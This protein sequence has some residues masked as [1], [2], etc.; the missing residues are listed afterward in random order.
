MSNAKALPT[1][2]SGG[3]NLSSR[4]GAV[5]EDVTLYHS[6]VGALQY[7][8]I[9]EAEYRSLANAT[10]EM[11]WI[12]SV[13]SELHITSSQ[14]PELWCDNMSTIVLSANPVLHSRT[15]LLELDL[16][17]VREKVLVKSLNVRHV[18]S[19]GQTALPNL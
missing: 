19:F 14:Q 2:M 18:P 12:R 13:L 8:T 5:F 7:L 3:V 9:T 4:D 15:K 1:P 6:T 11:L 17:F 10:S 16:H